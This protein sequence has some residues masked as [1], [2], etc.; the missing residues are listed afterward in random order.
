MEALVDEEVWAVLYCRG[1]YQLGM[2]ALRANSLPIEASATL[3]AATINGV[4]KEA[5]YPSKLTSKK[6]LPLQILQR[7]SLSF[8]VRFGRLDFSVI[9][10]FS[11]GFPFIF[12]SLTPAPVPY[13]YT[14][15]IF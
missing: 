14:R 3:G 15:D 8:P 2:T 6:P 11:L 7:S 12:T 9:F 10:R 1:Q 4:S 5:V 13:L